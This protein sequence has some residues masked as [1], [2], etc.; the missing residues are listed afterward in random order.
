MYWARRDRQAEGEGMVDMSM[1]KKSLK[2][3]WAAASKRS[4]TEARVHEASGCWMLRA[5]ASNPTACASVT[6]ASAW[7]IEDMPPT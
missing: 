2:L 3:V 1:E 6:S 5:K 7:L 4:A